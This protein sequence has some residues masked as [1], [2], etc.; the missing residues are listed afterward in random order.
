MQARG[1]IL[2][3]WNWKNFL[4]IAQKNINY[5]FEK[6]DAQDKYGSENYFN[7]FF[8]GRSLRWTAE[9]VYGFGVSDYF[10]EKRDEIYKNICGEVERMNL[11]SKCD[12]KKY[13]KMFKDVGG[14]SLWMEMKIK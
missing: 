14:S 5:A 3:G 7:A 10:N 2:K 9:I 6:S 8:G 12:L 4:E 11:K 13:D 1:V